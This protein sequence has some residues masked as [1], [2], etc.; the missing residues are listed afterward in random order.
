MEFSVEEVVG[1][2]TKQPADFI[3]NLKGDD[4]E[5]KSKDEIFAAI[6]KADKDRLD[7]IAKGESGKAVRLRMKQAQNYIKEN[8]GIE[9]DAH[10][11]EDHLKLL[12]ESVQSKAGKEKIVEKLVELDEVSALQHPIVK[13]LLKS[14]VT[15]NTAELTRQLEDEKKKFQTFVEEGNRKK[16]D[17]QLM[18]WGEKA[19]VDAKAD[20]KKDVTEREKQIR[21]FINGLKADY[22][23]KP[24]EAEDTPPIVLGA[25]GEPLQEGYADVN[26]TDL[27]K[28]E[29]IF[30]VLEFDQDKGSPSATT[31]TTTSQQRTNVPVPK[32][33]EEFNEVIKKETDPDKR[34]AIMEAFE[35]NT[36]AA[37]K[38]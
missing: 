31:Q 30:R 16:L 3:P 24:S 21:R 20:L 5:W 33:F 18:K 7:A 36:K 25:D 26:Y 23:F 9:S 12:V 17:T 37:E 32:T 2:I 35:A 8:F 28:R 14:E 29:N 38:K 22:K 4:G 34:K 11:I 27:V 1:L 13:G 19:L 6:R 10:E 15:K